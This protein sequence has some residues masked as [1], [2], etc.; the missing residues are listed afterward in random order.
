[1]TKIVSGFRHNFAINEKGELY[2]WGFNSM[3]Q[4]ANADEYIDPEN[5]K[6]AI[7]TPTQILGPLEKKFVVDVAAGE[8][9]SVIVA[10]TRVN[11]VTVAEQV[12]SCGNNLK[13]QLGIN[14][15]SHLNDLTL[16]EDISELFDMVDEHQK[17]LLIKKI[18][19][20]RRFCMA[21]FEY[22]AFFMWGDN[23]LG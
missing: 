15:V 21:A 13:G 8:E 7:F 12:F 18:A 6:Q 1:M 5:P 10:Q 11:N 17:P 20:G 22:G 4:L 14:R 23:E 3:M 9:H 2:G 16:V 19:C